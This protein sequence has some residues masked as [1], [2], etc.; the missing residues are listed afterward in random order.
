MNLGSNIFKRSSEPLETQFLF[1][2][3]SMLIQ[4]FN[5]ILYH[6]TFPVDEDTDTL[7]FQTV[8]TL[9]LTP[10]IVTKE[11]KKKEI[12]IIGPNNNNNNHF[13]HSGL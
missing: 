2:R 5:S 3:V 8:L 1:Q 6:E 12:M 11:C 7:P 4:R 13:H 10:G 9:F